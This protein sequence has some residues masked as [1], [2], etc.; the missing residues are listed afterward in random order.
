[1]LT[2]QEQRI[3]VFFFEFLRKLPE[4]PGSPRLFIHHKRYG[5]QRYKRHIEFLFNKKRPLDF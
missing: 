2:T 1:M 4:L 3:L 5:H